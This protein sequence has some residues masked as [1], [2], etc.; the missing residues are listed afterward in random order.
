VINWQSIATE[1]S[2]LDTDLYIVEH[3]NPSDLKRFAQ[4]SIDTINGW[5]LV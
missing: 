5:E 4:R 2:S 3:D 1:L